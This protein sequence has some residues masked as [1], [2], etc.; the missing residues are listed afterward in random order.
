MNS[1]QEDSF[2][3]PFKEIAAL[4]RY[5]SA[6]SS[7]LGTSSFVRGDPVDNSCVELLQDL[8]G[9]LARA[10]IIVQALRESACSS[11]MKRRVEDIDWG[12]RR[13]AYSSLNQANQAQPE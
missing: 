9:H 11:S 3:F 10:D 8:P 13:L 6:L 4:I 12:L 7:F 5:F 1:H 2:E